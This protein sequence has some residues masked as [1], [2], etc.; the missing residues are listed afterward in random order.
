MPARHFCFMR[1]LALISEPA[2]LRSARRVFRVGEM[3]PIKPKLFTCL[4]GELSQGIQQCA[5]Q[6][7]LTIVRGSPHK[8]D[9]LFSALHL[10]EILAT[11][12]AGR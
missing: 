2:P 7:R 12:G 4:T 5:G 6:P 3:I 9:I 11:D 8:I 1:A 10:I